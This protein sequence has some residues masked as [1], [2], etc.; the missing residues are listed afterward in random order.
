ME[1]RTLGVNTRSVLP[2]ALIKP[3]TFANYQNDNACT[4]RRSSGFHREGSYYEGKRLEFFVDFGSNDINVIYEN[5]IEN[6]KK[7]NA[8]IG[9]VEKRSNVIA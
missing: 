4:I 7:P 8:G 9:S 3:T 1:K 5:G 2:V 6:M